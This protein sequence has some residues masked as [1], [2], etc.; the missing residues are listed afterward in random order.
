MRT[1]ILRHDTSPDPDGLDQQGQRWLSSQLPAL[2]PRSDLDRPLSAEERMVAGDLV[3]RDVAAAICHVTAWYPVRL[4]TCLELGRIGLLFGEKTLP[5]NRHEGNLAGRPIRASQISR[6]RISRRAESFLFKLRAVFE[7]G[8]ITRCHSRYRV[9]RE[10]LHMPSSCD[11][12]MIRDGTC[13]R[14]T[15]RV[16]VSVDSSRSTVPSTLSPK[17]CSMTSSN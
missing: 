5:R 2:S 16:Y 7:G 9:D 13:R 1:S 6:I 11:S 10:C 4:E 12:T 8:S 14:C 17:H 15:D 3:S